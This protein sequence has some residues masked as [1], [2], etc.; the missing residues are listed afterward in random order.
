MIFIFSISVTILLLFILGIF[1]ERKAWNKGKYPKCSIA[2]T[3]FDY[4][5][6]C[7]RGYTCKKC[8]KA[9]WISYPY[10]GGR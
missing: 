10:V 7:G 2:W 4:D 5:S 1:T 3:Y 9:I 6:Q 8:D